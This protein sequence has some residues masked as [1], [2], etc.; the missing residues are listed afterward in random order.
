MIIR[1]FDARGLEHLHRQRRFA[2]F[3]GM[4]GCIPVLRFTSG[5]LR[6]AF[7]ITLAETD[8]ETAFEAAAALAR[9]KA[10]GA[11]LRNDRLARLLTERPH[12]LPCF[13]GHQQAADSPVRPFLTDGP[14]GAWSLFFEDDGRM[15]MVEAGAGGLTLA[16]DEQLLPVT[17]PPSAGGFLLNGLQRARNAI[18]RTRA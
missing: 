10:P 15:A 7:G 17:Q 1:V 4:F 14:A 11:R 5:E 2:G 12:L 8:V 13:V 6:E 16:P 3:E 18:A 9:R